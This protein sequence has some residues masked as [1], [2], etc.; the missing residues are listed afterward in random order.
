MLS[1]PEP[2]A[3]Y[4]NVSLLQRGK[5]AID[6]RFALANQRQG[7]S[8]VMVVHE[9]NRV[10]GF[11]ALAPTAVL[12]ASMN[13]SP[14]GGQ[15]PNPVPA[16]LL[17]QLATDLDWNERGVG[18]ALLAHALRRRAIGAGADFVRAAMT[19]RSFFAASPIS[20]QR[21][22]QPMA[23][24]GPSSAALTRSKYPR[25]A[26]AGWA[27]LLFARSRHGRR[28]SLGLRRRSAQRCVVPILAGD[29]A[30]VRGRSVLSAG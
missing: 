10:V 8:V 17:G 30:D 29:R 4:H 7:F 22:W 18:S 23:R 3:A 13:R 5:P 6:D 16:L 15:L 19:R 12:P 1:P 26:A 24:R 28:R 21:S 27:A 25:A 20:L 11:Y 14:R 2:I 9:D